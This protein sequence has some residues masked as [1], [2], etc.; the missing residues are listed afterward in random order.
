MGI[1]DQFAISV[2]L[3]GMT[4]PS[5]CDVLRRDKRRL[6]GD[7]N[8]AMSRLGALRKLMAEKPVSTYVVPSED[9][10][11]YAVRLA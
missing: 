11:M 6:S 7:G 9:Q 8:G 3:D 4:S 2:V 5:V 10:R 1:A